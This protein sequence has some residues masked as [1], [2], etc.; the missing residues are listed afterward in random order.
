[1]AED[2]ELAR[3][4]YPG[5]APPGTTASIEVNP[6]NPEQVILCLSSGVFIGYGEAPLPPSNPAV[7]LDKGETAV[8]FQ[9]I[10]WSTPAGYVL[11]NKARIIPFGGARM[12]PDRVSGLASVKGGRAVALAM[13]PAGTGYGYWIDAY[14]N[15]T[16]MGQVPPL[17]HSS[18]K[19]SS[20]SAVN[21]VVAWAFD[22]ENKLYLLLRRTGDIIA[23]PQAKSL[24]S[25]VVNLPKLRQTKA[26]ID[27]A[28]NFAAGWGYVLD[29]YGVLRRIGAAP[30]LNQVTAIWDQKVARSVAF[31][32]Y[33]DSGA[34]SY[35]TA[36]D[37]GSAYYRV[38]SEAPRVRIIAPTGESEVQVITIPNTVTSFRLGFEGR[39][40]SVISM[41]AD[42]VGQAM[43]DALG[44]VVGAGNV[45]VSTSS[46]GSGYFLSFLGPM[47]SRPQPLVTVE[48]ITGTGTPAVMRSM[49]SNPARITT[50]TR[51]TISWLYEDAE[52][53]PQSEWEVQVWRYPE[54]PDET[55]TTL[56]VFSSSHVLAW[57]GAG[58]GAGDSSATVGVDLPDG[59]YA[60]F[61]RSR[62]VAGRWSEW[63]AIVFQM[64][65]TRPEVPGLVL[66]P[67]D[68]QAAV[69]ISFDLDEMSR[70]DG[71]AYVER[72]V[73]GGQ[74]WD[75]VRGSGIP[76]VGGEFVERFD[77][78]DGPLDEPWQQ[79]SPRPV[80]VSGAQ[81]VGPDSVVGSGETYAR[82]FTLGTDDMMSGPNGVEESLP[83]S[84]LVPRGDQSFPITIEDRLDD[85]RYD[86]FERS[87][88]SGGGNVGG[89]IGQ[90]P[91]GWA[92]TK[93]SGTW[94]AGGGLLRA[95]KAGPSGFTFLSFNAG[96]RDG[97][98]FT[99]IDFRAP[100]GA[101]TFTREVGFRIRG[102]VFTQYLV[103][104]TNDDWSTDATPQWRI[105]KVR[106][107]GGEHPAHSVV[108]DSGD[109]TDI[110][111]LDTRMVGAS[112]EGEGDETT[113]RIY[114]GGEVVSTTVVDHLPNEPFGGNEFGLISLASVS[115]DCGRFSGVR[116]FRK[117]PLWTS[118]WRNSSPSAAWE[119]LADGGLRLWSPGAE[120]EALL[121]REI[122]MSDGSVRATLRSA[123]GGSIDASLVARHDPADDSCLM[124]A[125][126]GEYSTD[127]FT[128]FHFDGSTPTVLA[129][130]PDISPASTDIGS[131]LK[132]QVS[133]N[134]VRV[135]RHLDGQG[136]WAKLVPTADITAFDPT[137]Y[138]AVGG[139][140]F[141]SGAGYARASWA[142]SG[143][144]P[145]LESQTDTIST[146]GTV[147]GSLPIDVTLESTIDVKLQI[148]VTYIDGAA[149]RSVHS[150][151]IFDVE[152]GVEGTYTVHG[153]ATADVDRITVTVIAI[154]PGGAGSFD[155]TEVV[156][157]GT[158]SFYLPDTVADTLNNTWWGIGGGASSP[159]GSDVTDPLASAQEWMTT[160]TFSEVLA[161]VGPSGRRAEENAPSDGV[162]PVL[163]NDDLVV[164]DPSHLLYDDVDINS[165]AAYCDWLTT[166]RGALDDIVFSGSWSTNL[167]RTI[168]RW[169]GNTPFS[170]EARLTTSGTATIT[171]GS[172]YDGSP[173][174]IGYTAASTSGIRVVVSGG[175]TV[176]QTHASESADKP[177]WPSV[178]RLTSLTP[179]A[180]T[181]TISK[182]A[183]STRTVV[184]WWGIR[185]SDPK[186]VVMGAP[187][188][189]PFD[190]GSEFYLR[191]RI[192]IGL[193]LF[194]IY[195]VPIARP[196]AEVGAATITPEGRFVEPDGRALVMSQIAESLA[197]A[198]GAGQETSAAVEM[199]DVDAQVTITGEAAIEVGLDDPTNPTQ[200][201]KVEIQP[202]LFDG[203]DYAKARILQHDA[204]DW[205]E[206]ATVTLPN[207]PEGGTVLAQVFGPT[208]TTLG[209]GLDDDETNG[210]GTLDPLPIERI[211]GGVEVSTFLEVSHPNLVVDVYVAEWNSGGIVIAPSTDDGLVQPGI[212]FLADGSVGVPTGMGTPSFST[213]FVAESNQKVTVVT[214][215]DWVEAYVGGVLVLQTTYDTGESEFS[216]P[217]GRTGLTRYG[218]TVVSSW[219]ISKGR[220]GHLQPVDISIFRRGDLPGSG[221]EGTLGFES[222]LRN[223]TLDYEIDHTYGAGLGGF[224]ISNT[225]EI[226]A[227]DAGTPPNVL[228]SFARTTVEPTLDSSSAS[229]T[230]FL[231]SPWVP[232]VV[233]TEIDVNT[234]V[235]NQIVLSGAFADL[236]ADEVW[237]ATQANFYG[238]WFEHAWSV[239][240]LDKI[241]ETVTYLGT[242]VMTEA[243]GEDPTETP[244]SASALP[245]SGTIEMNEAPFTHRIELHPTAI[246]ETAVTVE[247]SVGVSGSPTL[248]VPD[249]VGAR[250]YLVDSLGGGDY[251]IEQIY[252]S[253]AMSTP[254]TDIPLTFDG[255]TL[256]LV[257]PT[258]DRFVLAVLTIEYLDD[259]DGTRTFDLGMTVT[260][261]N[262]ISGGPNP[263]EIAVQTSTGAGVTGASST[264]T[265]YSS[266]SPAVGVLV[267]PTGGGGAPEGVTVE[268]NGAIVELTLEDSP[269]YIADGYAVIRLGEDSTMDDV[270]L[271]R[272]PALIRDIEANLNRALIYRLSTATKRGVKSLDGDTVT[273]STI[274][275]NR[276]HW[277]KSPLDGVGTPVALVND[278]IE[279]FRAE[280]QGIFDPPGRET[281]IVVGGIVRA[282]RI[283]TQV[284]ATS[285]SED[286]EVV[287]ALLN[288]GRVLLFQSPWGGQHYVRFGAEA[289]RKLIM[290]ALYDENRLVEITASDPVTVDRP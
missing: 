288:S 186:I 267:T 98:I 167:D 71:L 171:L 140:S 102:G 88:L 56:P 162:V 230:Q 196:L 260:Y 258:V 232:E 207:V 48:S 268:I 130:S 33:G 11:T 9:V 83:A 24:P 97:S 154:E 131:D 20:T 4:F 21:D 36:K 216:S 225:I 10:D 50:T 248:D 3:N 251:A 15:P 63:D 231:E 134:W 28:Y 183:S 55:P 62:E 245:A 254:A 166:N 43:E 178:V 23:S 84:A 228:R 175:P 57:R 64:A 287:M 247:V 210:A 197:I 234:S 135:K 52:S 191:E 35:W 47:G 141:S 180:H 193:F 67:L 116:F 165:I 101:V 91:E 60:A 233:A 147:G 143:G 222:P 263:T 259:V 205:V 206:R 95:T 189:F 61:I 184:T 229:F 85:Q 257:T 153:I 132:F 280:E 219:T 220:S 30:T 93:S 79:T 6:T 214:S 173:V 66:T 273:A 179:G 108:V 177:P 70:T 157:G 223:Y 16:P 82:A 176:E 144:L 227:L 139:S 103:L 46:S 203:A 164:F 235:P 244:F 278:D 96:T 105:V 213:D 148:Q 94:V 285:N 192:A 170:G 241:A 69:E 72:S 34:M 49:A 146:S 80:E 198:F 255:P 289:S 68:E 221:A 239:Y 212:E 156:V 106:F 54:R 137:D 281:S 201:L 75:P 99:N 202:G 39:T 237:V 240:R 283:G 53:D 12:V 211:D 25:L 243:T 119:R 118:G 115:P 104:F 76:V 224:E 181:I 109:M 27:I 41:N 161:S 58:R 120:G 38:V 199:S 152:G 89:V 276:R 204:G 159:V 136:V 249:V 286:E 110:G 40:T 215:T 264:S 42:D 65:P 269:P 32:S 125:P 74:S 265:T 290:G 126:D 37:V 266:S 44:A 174:Y 242:Q 182:P 284:F 236:T 111:D 112:I 113:I 169:L 51:P 100:T 163:N 81:A 17:V 127:G 1:M 18:N 172:D 114:A 2:N 31:G 122:G 45:A 26:A 149:V 226:N 158:T 86:N 200:G 272:Y 133:G 275:H 256:G 252:D 155:V 8:D 217:R 121:T 29:E 22:W 142:G 250:M 270:I 262:T 194:G 282:E 5:W 185:Q 190:G 168:H 188:P 90:S 13:D 218:A 279:T 271:G 78:D 7:I 117:D 145:G 73:D 124:L 277:L 107:P 138:T 151:G 87:N 92:W 261:R 187:I 208:E 238:G 274:L 77:Q 253:G 209:L 195:F 19:V 123:A 160:P 14:G 129:T 246:A 59:Y 128:L 150:S